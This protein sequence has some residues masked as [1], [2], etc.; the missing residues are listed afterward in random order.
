MFCIFC[1]RHTFRDLVVSSFSFRDGHWRPL[2]F[3]VK[4]TTSAGR[5]HRRRR[6]RHFERGWQGTVHGCDGRRGCVQQVLLEV[7]AD[8]NFNTVHFLTDGI[9]IQF[10]RGCRSTFCVTPAVTTMHVGGILFFRLSSE[11]QTVTQG[12]EERS[13]LS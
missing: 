8:V 11:Y 2:R 6:W 4:C 9:S 13:Q 12:Y 5:G 10:L 1:A 3:A 7:G